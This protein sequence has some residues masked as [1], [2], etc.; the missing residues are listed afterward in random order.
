MLV[1]INMMVTVLRPTGSRTMAVAVHL[2][3]AACSVHSTKLRM[4]MVLLSE[5]VTACCISVISI[6]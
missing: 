5:R 4:M 3:R 6:G 1:G 2:A